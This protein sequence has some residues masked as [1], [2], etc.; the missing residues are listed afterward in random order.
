MFTRSTTNGESSRAAFV[1][2]PTQRLVTSIWVWGACW[3]LP[4]VALAQD[5]LVC[6][7]LKAAVADAPQGFAAYKGALAPP[8]K[9]AQS[10]GKTHQAKKVMSG[11]KACSV[12]GVVLDDPKKQIRQTAY[13]CQYPAVFQLDQALRAEL[14]RCVAGEVDDA[15]DPKDFTIWVDRVSSGEGY[16][17]TEVTAQVN[18]ADGMKLQVR[19]SACTNKGDHLTCED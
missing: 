11:A 12:V 10:L 17:A 1:I 13:Q 3:A 4:T 7:E 9:A 5:R 19:V 6:A 8:G 15:A 2:R 16:S 14:T 18:A